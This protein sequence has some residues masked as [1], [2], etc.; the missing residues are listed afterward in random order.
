MLK[1][2]C[3]THVVVFRKCR[4]EL[5]KSLCVS[6]ASLWSESKLKPSSKIMSPGPMSF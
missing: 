3:L 1:E 2:H 6:A 5:F 4:G